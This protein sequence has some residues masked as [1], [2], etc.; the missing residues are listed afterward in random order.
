[1]R[2]LTTVLLLFCAA[3]AA[4]PADPSAE[5]WRVQG[6]LDRVDRM[7]R[8][9]PAKAC[10]DAGWRFAAARPDRGLTRADV[11]TLQR[12]ILAWYGW[13]EKQLGN[14][15]RLAIGFGLL[16]ADGLGPERLH[17]AFDADADGIVTRPELLADV[18]L[19][20]RPLGQVLADPNAVD[21]AAIARRLKLPDAMVRRLFR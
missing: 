5:A 20:R 13:R 14:R 9:G 11:E 16:L 6:F 4:Q 3:A 17:A 18:R 8:T 10:V 21:R 2:I 19:D 15:E 1:M 7:C 12:R